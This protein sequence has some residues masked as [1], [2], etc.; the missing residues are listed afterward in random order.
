MRWPVTTKDQAQVEAMRQESMEHDVRAVAK[1]QEFARL[2]GR[3]SALM[4]LGARRPASGF[5]DRRSVTAPRK[6]AI[7]SSTPA[8]RTSKTQICVPAT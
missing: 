3:L 4:L 5:R 8:T 6:M 2:L 7:S 1:T